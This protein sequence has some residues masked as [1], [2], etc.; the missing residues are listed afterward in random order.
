MIPKKKLSD[1]IIV[2]FIVIFAVL[3]IGIFIF[4]DKDQTVQDPRAMGLIAPTPQEQEWMEKNLVDIEE[5]RLNQLGV[6][7]INAERAEK[8]LPPLDIQPVPFGEEIVMKPKT[9]AAPYI[10]SDTA[11]TT[12]AYNGDCTTGILTLRGMNLGSTTVHM[13]DIQ[14][15]AILRD[16]KTKLSASTTRSESYFPSSGIKSG[17]YGFVAE[18]KET[19]LQS[20][21][22]QVRVNVFS[23]TCI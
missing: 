13:I 22:Y 3:A 5:I 2:I 12:T 20:E 8:G 19:G 7:R 6:D 23:F 15:G 18:D 1:R 11:T 10:S 14:T 17:T 4:V 9:T 16:L 21:M